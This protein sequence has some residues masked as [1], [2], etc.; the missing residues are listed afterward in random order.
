MFVLSDP[1]SDVQG[2]TLAI[3]IARMLDA[4][5]AVAAGFPPEFV[6]GAGLGIALKR[7]LDNV[8]ELAASYG[9]RVEIKEFHGNPVRVLLDALRDFDLMVVGVRKGKKAGLLR[10]SVEHNLI[11]SAPCSVMVLPY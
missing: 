8:R 3:D 5:L 10:P 11:H 7:T 1:D 2:V 4:H 9:V 6:S